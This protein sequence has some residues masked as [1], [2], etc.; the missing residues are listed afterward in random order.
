MQRSRDGKAS[1]S[2]QAATG[3]ETPVELVLVPVA[4]GSRLQVQAADAGALVKGLGLYSHAS[5][6]QLN[7]DFLLEPG[8][9]LRAAGVLKAESFTLREAPT[10]VEM[11]PT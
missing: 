2:L 5:G 8:R 1:A 6:G 7:A 9:P 10:L 11:L 3:P 4:D